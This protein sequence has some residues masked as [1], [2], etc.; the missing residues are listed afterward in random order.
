MTHVAKR[1]ET[2]LQ[3]TTRNVA[4]HNTGCKT[5]QNTLQNARF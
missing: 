5:Q 3:K 2:V 1:N 4:K